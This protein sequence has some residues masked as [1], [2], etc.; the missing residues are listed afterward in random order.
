[1]LFAVAQ[2]LRILIMHVKKRKASKSRSSNALFVILKSVYKQLQDDHIQIVAAGIAF[3]VF[4]SV[5]PALSG[6]LSLY[7][8]LVG[9]EQAQEQLASASAFL[10]QEVQESIGT[11]VSHVSGKSNQALGIGFGV[12]LFLSIWSTNKGTKALFEGL[13]I[14]YDE[15]D[16]RS[17]L[18][19]NG[20][21]LLFTF[22]ALVCCVV[23]IALIT[24]I[25]A[26]IGRVNFSKEI[27]DLLQ[28]G[29]WPVSA[30]ISILLLAFAYKIAPDRSDG[31]VR[32]ISWGSMIATVLWMGGSALFSFYAENFGSFGET[33]GSFAAVVLLMLWLF[34]S[35]F[36][37]LVG[38]E[39]NSELEKWQKER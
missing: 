7:G 19:L 17:F 23:A 29:R 5:F 6:A 1:M 26:M 32:W 35:S 2:F 38:A 39:V 13:N 16:D 3:Y 30:V 24:L 37:I 15:K 20:L 27:Q 36:F 11:I 9:A 25:P 18:V 10:P 33:Y 22:I 34:L 8:L 28:F 14:A 4:L 31:E 21:S 12:S